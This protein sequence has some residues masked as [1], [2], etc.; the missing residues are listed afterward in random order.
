MAIN[1]TKTIGRVRIGQ[2]RPTLITSPNHA[3]KVNV[4]M[5]DIVDVSVTDLQNGYTLIYNSATQKYEVSQIKN[6]S[7]ANITGGIF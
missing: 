4:A 3:V 5:A 7:P 2:N 6:L 1:N